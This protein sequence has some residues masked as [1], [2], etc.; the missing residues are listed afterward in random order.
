MTERISFLVSSTIRWG[1]VMHDV[2]FEFSYFSCFTLPPLFA[3]LVFKPSFHILSFS[4]FF[5]SFHPFGSCLAFRH[6][7]HFCKSL[8]NMVCSELLLNLSL[9]PSSVFTTFWLVLWDFDLLN[10]S[11]Q[12]TKNIEVCIP[13]ACCH[14][15]LLLTF[16]TGGLSFLSINQVSRCI[17]V[18]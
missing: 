17:E 7:A 8:C 16:M 6:F 15:S 12:T 1:M 9:Y 11:F 4:P 14:H 2:F 3:L 18:L 10:P 5:T 13:F